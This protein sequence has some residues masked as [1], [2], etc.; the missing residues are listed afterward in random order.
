MPSPQY[1]IV[2]K[3]GWVHCQVLSDPRAKIF[4]SKTL[5]WPR[6]TKLNK[7]EFIEFSNGSLYV[8][9]AQLRYE[10]T[11]YCTAANSGGFEF[12]SVQVKVGG[13][14]KQVKLSVRH[15]TCFICLIYDVENWYEDTWNILP[16]ISASIRAVSSPQVK[17]TVRHKT[18]FIC[19]IYDV[20][21]WYEDT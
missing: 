4:W 11:Y 10:G 9:K 15:K 6:G 8:R 14:E 13:M 3:P 2:N 16:I 7:L 1:L 21:N 5:Q 19:L 18:C 20:E 12:K 17:L